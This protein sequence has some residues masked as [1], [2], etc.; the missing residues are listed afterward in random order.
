MAFLL[1]R[2]QF[3][4]RTRKGFSAENCLLTMI[5]KWKNAVDKREVV[6][7]LSANL[8]LFVT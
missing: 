7:G 2:C 6:G 1:S 3:G 5:V 8:G 4:F